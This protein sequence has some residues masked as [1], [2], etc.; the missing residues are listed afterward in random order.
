[1]CLRATVPRGALEVAT[2]SPTW[3]AV[4]CGA[5]RGKRVPPQMCVP[6]RATFS[7]DEDNG[8]QA[9]VL[10]KPRPP[11]TSG[12]ETEPPCMSTLDPSSTRWSII[13]CDGRSVDKCRPM[14][15]MALH[16]INEGSGG[17]VLVLVVPF[18]SLC[19]PIVFAV[20]MD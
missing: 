10:P 15:A 9:S 11:P 18:R 13:E 1:M 7:D 17:L 6:P 14:N 12:T 4:V 19:A 5:Q 20:T 2:H 8:T 3:R 16:F